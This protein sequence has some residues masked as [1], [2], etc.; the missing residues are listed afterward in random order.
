MTV[1][2]DAAGDATVNVATQANVADI[3]GDVLTFTI[4]GDPTGGTAAI[5]PAGVL[6]YD[7]TAM[8][9]A[10]D[11]LT[12]NVSDGTASTNI[13][14]TVT[15]T[16][17]PPDVTG[18]VDQTVDEDGTTTVDLAALI[19]NN[20]GNLVFGPATASGGGTAAINAAGPS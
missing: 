18:L 8:T 20:G 5:T 12:V 2:L 10:D 6:T 13:V 1:V 9:G 17:L 11:T 4:S 16:P 14:V 19:G 7:Q 3:D 15:E